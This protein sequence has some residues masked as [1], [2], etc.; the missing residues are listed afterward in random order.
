MLHKWKFWNR[1]AE[2]RSEALRK[3]NTIQ[4]YLDEVGNCDVAVLALDTL[5]QSIL[6]M[7][8]VTVARSKATAIYLCELF[9]ANDI[10]V[11][12]GLKDYRAFVEQFDG[13]DS[14]SK[15]QHSWS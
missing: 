7:N 2:C 6:H 4:N 1:G 3:I 12:K 10:S 15:Y 9:D 13:V 11:K 8:L 5:T 14:F